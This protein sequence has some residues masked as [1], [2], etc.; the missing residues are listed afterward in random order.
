MNS[1]FNEAITLM[2]F[3]MGFVFVF[4]TL[5]VFATTAMSN[6][7]N[8]YF[9]EPQVAPTQA[10]LPASSASGLQTAGDDDGNINAVIAAAVAR[11]RAKHNKK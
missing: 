5:L 4:L 3:G 10:S 11:Y 6:I 7:I 8:K 9:P 1:I 2:I